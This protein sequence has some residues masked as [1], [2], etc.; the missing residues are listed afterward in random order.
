MAFKSC[1]YPGVLSREADPKPADLLAKEAAK[2]EKQNAKSNKE[3]NKKTRKA[4]A[5]S[6]SKIALDDAEDEP[7][8]GN[9]IVDENDEIDESEASESEGESDGLGDFTSDSESEIPEQEPTHRLSRAA[10]AIS[11]N[12]RAATNLQFHSV[13]RGWCK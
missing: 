3:T 7:D 10:H 5:D 13:A 2:E 12:Q 9:D 11:Y 8:N 4:K 6:N 1:V